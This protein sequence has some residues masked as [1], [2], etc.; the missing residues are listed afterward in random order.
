MSATAGGEIRLV[1][2]HMMKGA[3][4]DVWANGVVEIPDLAR[5]SVDSVGLP[6]DDVYSVWASQINESSPIVG[7][8][9]I[10]NTSEGQVFTFVMVGTRVSNNRVVVFKQSV[11]TI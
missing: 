3:A 6:A 5:G 2:A 10:D 1:A 4:V 7:P 8:R 9:V 11:G